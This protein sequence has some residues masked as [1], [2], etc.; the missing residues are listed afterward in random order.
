MRLRDALLGL[1]MLAGSVPAARA[2]DA[3]ATYPSRPVVIVVPVSPGGALD[4]M[5][6][7]VAE[8]FRAT[9]R[10][11]VVVENRAGANTDIGNLYVARSAP[12]GHTLLLQSDS[13]AANASIHPNPDYDPIRSFQPVALLATAPGM[14]VV[15]RDMDARS[16]AEF[17]ALA[18]S[19]GDGLTVAST[20]TGTTSHLTGVLLKQSLGL[21]WTDVPYPGSGRAVTDLLGGHVDALWV[22]SAAVMPYLRSGEMRAIAVSSPQRSGAFPEVATVAETAVPGFD[23]TNWQGLLAP[24]GTPQPIVARLAA[25][26]ARMMRE[27]DSRRK[28]EEL[29]LEPSGAGPEVLGAELRRAVPKWAEVAQRAGLRSQ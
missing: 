7:L 5:A 10:A 8:Q 2:Q 29:G 14:L 22:M 15:R 28:V 1:A 27:P 12:D 26:V 19:R 23:V 18:R 21:R 11:P 24:A 3:T 25:E 17:V 16:L 6:R 20:G 4:I 9:F 13:L